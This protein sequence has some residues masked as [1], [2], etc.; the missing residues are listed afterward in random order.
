MKANR[1][2]RET[3]LPRPPEPPPVTTIDGTEYLVKDCR[4][5]NGHGGHSW[6]DAWG[7]LAWCRGH[8]FDRT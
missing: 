7:N 6:T 4:A 5:A 1:R 8:S 3:T 2:W